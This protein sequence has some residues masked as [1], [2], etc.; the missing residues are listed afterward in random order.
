[1]LE[2]N[3]NTQNVKIK[4]LSALHDSNSNVL[5]LQI[6]F[7]EGIGNFKKSNYSKKNNFPKEP[8]ISVASISKI[9]PASNSL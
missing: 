3:K 2:K 5:T 6:D 8:F 4:N 1:M 9:G 7:E